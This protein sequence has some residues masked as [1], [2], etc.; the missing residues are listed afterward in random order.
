MNVRDTFG[1][2]RRLALTAM[3]ASMG[4]TLTLGQITTGGVIGRILDEAGRPLAG[5]HVTLRNSETGLEREGITNDQGEYVIPG[6]PPAVYVVQATLAEYG[7]PLRSVVVNLGQN[8]PLD[9]VMRPGGGLK[10][11]VTVFSEPELLN[12]T[13]PEI[14]TVVTERAIQ[15]FPL[16]NRDYNDLALFAPG[17]KQ[18]VG[19]QFDPIKKPGI[20]TPFTTGGTAGRNVNISIDGADNNDNIVGSFVQGISA[21]SIR[22]FQVIQD[23]FKPEYGRSFGGVVNVITKSGTNEVHGSVFGLFRNENLRARNFSEEL[24]AESKSDSDRQAYGLSLGGPL[25]KNRL[26]Y[27]VAAEKQSEDNPSTLGSPLTSFAGTEPAGFPFQIAQPGTT[28]NR[29]LDRNML[30]ARIDWNVSPDHLLWVR[31]AL[32]EADSANDQGGALT[33]PSNDGSSKN[34]TSS[35]VLNWQWILSGRMIN[36]LK[37]HHN[38]FVNRID[39]SSPDQVLTLAYGDFSLGRNENLPQATFQ[40]KSQIR[41]DFTWLLGRHTFKAGAEV[42]HVDLDDSLLGPTGHAVIFYFNPG[43]DPAGSFVNGDANGNGVDDG[44]EVIQSVALISPGIVPGTKYAQYA[45]YF[46]DDWDFSDRWHLS[47]GLR[48]D[49]D[50]NIFREAHEGIN[51]QYYECFADPNDAHKC[52]LDPATPNPSNGPLRF[53]RFQYTLPED[54]TNI[55]P[56]LGFVY[57]INGE[58]RD[59]IR[60]SW[61][62][63]YDRLFD[64]FLLFT[65]RNLS[66]FHSPTLP[67]LRGCESASD[68]TCSM[69]ELFAGS[70]PVPG[71]ARL[72]ADFTLANWEDPTSGL[73]AW[74]TGLSTIQGPGTFNDFVPL[75]S[76]DWKTPYT[77]SF[78]AGWGHAFSSRLTIDTNVVYRRGYRQPVIR[79]FGDLASGR[80]APFPVVVDTLTGSATYPGLV[81]IGSTEGKSEYRSLQTSLRG[82]YEHFD[83]A[84]NVNLSRAEGTQDSGSTLS[85][86]G[87]FDLFQGGNIEFTGGDINSEWGRISGDQLVYAFLYGSYRFGLGY[88]TAL[89]IAYGTRTA[90]DGLAGVDLNGDGFISDEYAGRRGS[91]GGDDLFNVNWRG[92]KRFDTGKGTGL[93]IYVDVFNVLNRVNYG[94]YVDHRQL[95]PVGGVNE[96]NPDYETPFGDTL[97]PPRTVQLGFRF[98]Y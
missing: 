39:S 11:T 69:T 6:L 98:T 44:I 65:R 70:S 17:V 20:Y 85:S 8:V 75:L 19:G 36:E 18:A 38:D 34:R 83:F 59:V 89:E 60:G 32:D 22:E 87:A 68:P 31:W 21:E 93:E 72:P 5:V 66:P 88:A 51:R 97:T 47:L 96:P 2:H 10:E 50:R 48:V 71:Y 30:T 95:V 67:A 23:Q 9:I 13:T 43:V 62:L 86:G 84:V 3:I 15:S 12:T 64:N 91:G 90:F 49:R 14:S 61:G 52:G 78:S 37:I 1:F 25:M 63:F 80:E 29:S 28:V 81:L 54:Q 27:F 77:S 24:N 56:R 94:F 92:S 40:K 4:W 35:T 58:A 76:P 82:Q 42:I 53:D 33:D 73:Q 74:L 26:F 16:I 7:A 46:Q 55:A 57:R 41:D 45:G 79:G